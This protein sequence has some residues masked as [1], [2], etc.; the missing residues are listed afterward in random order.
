MHIAL[1]TTS[2][3]DAGGGS[4]AAGG[5]VADF[6]QA[7]ASHARVTVVAAA[8][9]ASAV[10]EGAVAVHRFA[11]PR[12][13]LSLL[14]PHSPLDWPSILTTLRSGRDALEHLVTTDRPD[15]IFALWALPSG[16]WA[17]SMQQKHGVSYGTWALGSDIWSLG[18]VPVIRGV[19]GRVI[20][21]AALSYADGLAL[22]GDVKR[23]SG[24]DCEFLPSARRI[25]PIERAASASGAPYKLAF[26]GRWHR[27]KGVDLLLD[28]LQCLPEEDWVR[29]DEVRIF[30]GGPL[31]Q[32]VR[33]A[34]AG[35]RS[36][37]RPVSVGGYL[38][39]AAAAE[40]IAWSDY[41]LLPSRIES[42]P[43]I[44][45]DAAQIGRPIVATPV[46]DL[47]ELFHRYEF[48]FIAEAPDANAYAAAL[49]RA[50]RA[51]ASQF[52]ARL[53]MIAGDFDVAVTAERFARSA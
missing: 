44:F 33:D 35:L 36:Q 42:I 47:P 1:V 51:D 43:V 8:R 13:P 10:T 23:L 38:D 24:R 50:L 14:R 28:A 46:G 7:L 9:S 52:D 12:M 15:F 29:V 40:L 20:A 11:V 41:L 21:S 6:A 31:E 32:T 45:S 5:F 2:Y 53:A 37:A 25:A 17:R 19:L 30:G 27:N 16:Y 22:A 18:R 3:P 48:G 34:V 26:L 4:E 39:K 49:Q